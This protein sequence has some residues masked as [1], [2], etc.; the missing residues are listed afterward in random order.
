MKTRNLLLLALFITAALLQT[1]S[2]NVHAGTATVN[3]SG[4]KQ[5]IR[6]FGA[7]SVWSGALDN[8]IMNTLFNTMGL[9]ILRVLIAPNEKGNNGNYF[10][11]TDT[12]S[13]AR[14]TKTR[15]AIV[16]ATPRTP[17]ASMKTNNNTVHGS[18]K[19]SS[20]SAYANYLKTFANYFK[21]NGA[22]LHAIS[23]QN[24]PDWDPNYEGCTWTAAQF[25]KFINCG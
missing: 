23:L 22:S 16:F 20:Y 18:L 14:R 19:S 25:D 9:R 17:P 12:L 24:E 4:T 1:A 11:W 3:L 2:W 5:I 10:T 7:A 6:G 15:G 13:N 8:S 21:N